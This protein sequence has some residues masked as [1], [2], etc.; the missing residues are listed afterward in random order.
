MP[1]TAR[2]PIE[3]SLAFATTLDTPDH[4]EFMESYASPMITL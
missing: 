2:P 1:M 4:N 3:V